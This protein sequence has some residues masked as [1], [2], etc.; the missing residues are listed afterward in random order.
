[1]LENK[2]LEKA[3]DSKCPSFYRRFIDDVFGIWLYGEDS[4]LKFFE[5]ANNCHP[6]IRFTY[7]FGKSVPY[8]DTSIS[9]GGQHIST[10]LFT[11]PTDTHQYLLPSSDHPPHVHR[12]LPYGLAIRIHAIVSDPD[13][14]DA[15]FG[16]LTTFLRSRGYPTTLIR[17]QLEAV[18]TIPRQEVLQTRR[19]DSNANRV[20]LVCTWSQQLPPLSQ[21][22]DRSV[23]IL[24]ANARLRRVF[25]RPLVSY[26][27]P[28]NLRDLLVTTRPKQRNSRETAGTFPCDAARC[29]TCP[30]T[31]QAGIVP[32]PSPQGK[33]SCRSSNVVY[34]IV[35]TACNA[36]YIGETGCLLRE[37]M[38]G[39]RYSVNHKLDTPVAEHFRQKDHKMAVRV[40]QGTPEDVTMR[41]SL[42]KKWIAQLKEDD[43]FQVINRDEGADI[44]SL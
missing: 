4:L 19:R 3:P 34:A 17:K 5:H 22:I 7:A 27:R 13:V 24:Q 43:R 16:E 12:N 28:S 29:K 39:H 2:I 38:N 42:E 44:L 35:C 14:R 40:L 11:K 31:E 8:L 10:D 6:D 36:V 30:L 23:P 37:R 18:R 41:R 26:R 33:F 25:D 32:L 20:P 1:M 9:I 21:L 15:R